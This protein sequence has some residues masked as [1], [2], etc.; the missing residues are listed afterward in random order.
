[1]EEPQRQR[2]QSRGI[3]QTLP[4]EFSFLTHSVALPSLAND[5]PQSTRSVAQPPLPQAIQR[6]GAVGQSSKVDVTGESAK[7][8][9]QNESTKLPVS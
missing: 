7:N 2:K 8:E 3:P 9:E 5:F 1:M 4:Q 6:Q